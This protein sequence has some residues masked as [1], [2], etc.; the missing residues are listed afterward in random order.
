[1]P[2][3]TEGILFSSSFPPAAPGNQLC[4]PQ[5]NGGTPAQYVTFQPQAATANLLGVG[6]PDGVTLQVDANGVWSVVAGSGGIGSGGISASGGAMVCVV[7]QPD[8]TDGT[9]TQWILPAP[10]LAGTVGLAFVNGVL[11]DPLTTD[12]EYA[13]QGT[14]LTTKS[15]VKSDDKLRYY[16]IMGTPDSESGGSG[17]VTPV[18]PAQLR[19]TS[20]GYASIGSA[21]VTWPAGTQAGDLV[22]MMVAGSFSPSTPSGWTRVVDDTTGLD[23]LMGTYWK[24]MTSA[25]ISAGGVSV[26]MS[27]S[28]NSNWTAAAFL[29]PTLGIREAD[30]GGSIGGSSPLALGTTGSA[31]VG[32]TALY[33]ASCRN[34]AG[35]PPASTCSV[36]RGV[37]EQQGDDGNFA[38]Y[39]LFAESIASAGVV[40]AQVS[41]TNTLASQQAIVI[42]KGS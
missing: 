25:D 27:S 3:P 38:G 34:G 24:L 11:L 23:W 14:Q 15:A 42:V 30:G 39:C 41:Y 32:D 7:P 2:D 21:A 28:G 29:G 4:L 36:N 1:V 18:P 12:A 40:S 16:Y 13:V 6:R 9:R 33:F 22:V 5:S 20:S 17:G 10:V 8:P 26:T 37:L 35:G 31:S 19:S